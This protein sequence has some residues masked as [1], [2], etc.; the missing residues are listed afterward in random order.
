MTSPTALQSYGLTHSFVVEIDDIKLSFS[1]V[2]GLDVEL[3]F[4]AYKE[5]GVND[6]ALEF[7]SSRRSGKLVLEKGVGK[8]SKLIKWFDDIQ[9]GKF[10]KKSGTIE[11]KNA[12]G[13]TIRIWAFESAFP[14]KWSGPSL[15]ATGSDVAIEVIEL[16]YGGLKSKDKQ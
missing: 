12:S 3:E 6:G 4:D 2:S 9:A 5:G 10:V 7:V 1:K 14:V 11:L 15:D 16:S 8:V 13:K